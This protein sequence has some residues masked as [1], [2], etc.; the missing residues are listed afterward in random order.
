M[1][2][3]YDNVSVRLARTFLSIIKRL[4]C[5]SLLQSDAT[6][7][8]MPTFSH[9]LPPPPLGQGKEPNTTNVPV[10][11]SVFYWNDGYR[12]IIHGLRNH[13]LVGSC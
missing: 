11:K 4:S 2:A 8:P 3:F 12:K 9:E 6:F 10:L 13:L 5:W 7:P 1:Y